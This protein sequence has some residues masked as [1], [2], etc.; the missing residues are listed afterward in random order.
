ML[1]N[2]GK[3]SETI[4]TKSFLNSTLLNGTKINETYVCEEPTLTSGIIKVIGS[5]MDKLFSYPGGFWTKF[6]IF[7]GI[8]YIIQVIFSLAFDV[9]ELVLLVF[10]AI[11]RLVVWIYR[12]ITGR[13]KQDEQ[14]KKIM[15]LK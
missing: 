5:F 7:L 6:F 15:E 13:S 11:K 8:I 2:V 10:V 3:S 12:R 9:I 14:L 1:Q 4:I